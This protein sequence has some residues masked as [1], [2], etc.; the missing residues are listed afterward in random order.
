MG[1]RA[2]KWKWEAPVS[3]GL[4]LAGGALINTQRFWPCH[5]QLNCKLDLW[6]PALVLALP[7]KFTQLPCT[8]SQS[9]L[10]ISALAFNFFRSR[11]KVLEADEK[12]VWWWYSFLTTWV[13]IPV[14]FN[15]ELCMLPWWLRWWRVC[16]QCGRLGLD[17]WVR[18]IP[19]RRNWQ[20]S[21]VLLTGKSHGQRSLVNYR[22][23]GHKE[24]DTTER[25]TTTL[26]N[27]T[28]DM[29]QDI[30]VNFILNIF[31]LYI[32]IHICVCKYMH[33]CIY[34]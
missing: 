20:P 33:I 26:M 16:L 11:W 17:P 30:W 25:L 32:Y 31:K 21:P 8:S 6:Q 10:K 7:L 22:P 4:N 29:K 3:T 13:H 23:W 28:R 18:K 27:V 2:G 12:C 14:A 9:I 24:S 5:G 19:W 15:I 34:I 1:H